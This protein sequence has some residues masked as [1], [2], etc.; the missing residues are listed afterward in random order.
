M[1]G[2][3]CPASS[4]CTCT[5]GGG[6]DVT[7]SPEELAGA[8]A[9]HRSHGTTRTLVS[10]VTAPPDAWSSNSGWVADAVA[11]GPGPSGH[12]L[13]AHLEGP[14]LADARRGA[15][16]PAHLLMPDRRV[17]ARFL[18]AARGAVRSMTIAPELPGAIDLIGD[19]LDA[20]AVASIGHSDATYA[21]RRPPS[22]P[23]RAQPPTCSTACGPCTT[24]SLASSGR[25]SPP[26]SPA[27]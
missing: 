18:E 1:G 17:F 26:A 7:A 24:A 13:G 10:L 19:V 15:H 4:T 25:P 16:N 12:V 21:R 9:F 3:S 14:F 22:T 20:G 11:A 27:K 8:V 6:Y 23:V 5:A 2:G